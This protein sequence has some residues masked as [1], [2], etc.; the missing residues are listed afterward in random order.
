MGQPLI[1]LV[2]MFFL[3][4]LWRKL[5]PPVDRAATI[6]RNM[7]IWGTVILGGWLIVWKLEF[8]WP[9]IGQKIDAGVAG[10]G[11]RNA[12]SGI[13][14]V[15]WALMIVAI[16]VAGYRVYRAQKRR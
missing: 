12:V 8:L 13:S 7:L 15:L 9:L 5:Y 6:F 4:G 3:V 16:A 14:T 1:I 10:E 2:I 11:V